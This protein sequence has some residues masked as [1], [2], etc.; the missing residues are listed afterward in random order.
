MRLYFR[1]LE[2]IMLKNRK[3][4]QLMA[5]FELKYVKSTRVS[6]AIH[7]S[8]SISDERAK[9][10]NMQISDYV[11]VQLRDRC[12]IRFLIYAKV[13]RQK[14]DGG[15]ISGAAAAFNIWQSTIC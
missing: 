2:K 6:Q 7:L 13:I 9:R 5:G 8:I 4:T 14:R 15:L 3:E 12:G 10:I 1:E 11:C